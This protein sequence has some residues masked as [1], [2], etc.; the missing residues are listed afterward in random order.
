MCTS[1]NTFLTLTNAGKHDNIVTR[2]LSAPGLFMQRITTK[3]PDDGQIEVAIIALKSAL[4]NEFP[5]FHYIDPH[6]ALEAETVAD[7]ESPAEIPTE[8]PADE[9]PV[10]N[11]PAEDTP[12]APAEEQAE[13]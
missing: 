7:E 12:A 3:E 5:N 9:P 2:I 8:T 6:D 13:A 4:P 10:E 11:V 1:I